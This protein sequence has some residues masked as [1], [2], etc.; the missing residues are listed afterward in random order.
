LLC[1]KLLLLF[2]LLLFNV[3]CFEQ[4]AI[5]EAVEQRASE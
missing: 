1:R 2:V 3:A 4:P 5:E